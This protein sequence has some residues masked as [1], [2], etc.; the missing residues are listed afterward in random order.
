MIKEI[1]LLN[2]RSHQDST[3]TFS[4]GTNLL[5][6]MMGSGK[7]SILDGI[8]FALF[9]T[10][11]A[12]ERR[13]LKL[14]DIIRLNEKEAKVTLSLEWG[15]LTYKIERV[16]IRTKKST[17]S[18]ASLFKNNQ[19]L[20]SGTR[21]VSSY[22]EELLGIDYDLFTRAIYAEQ[23]NI[24]YFL[25]LDPRRRKQEIDRLLGLDRFEE[26]RTNIVS[27]I[28]RI[29]SNRK[30]LEQRF[31][32]QRLE[33]LTKKQS[34]LQ[35]TID[36]LSSKLGEYSTSFEKEQELLQS[37]QKRFQDLKQKK[38][39][40]D[41]L[42][43][44]HT[45]LS[46]SLDSLKKEL[47][48]KQA[49]P[50]QLNKSKLDLESKSKERRSILEQTRKFDS[51]FSDL[52]KQ[53]GLLESEV[54]SI[55]EDMKKSLELKEN[56]AKLLNGHSVDQLNDRSE[57]LEK[58]WISVNSEG[59]SLQTQV[60]EIQEAVNTL[61]PGTAECPIC[62]N[63][64][65][66]EHL[67]NLKQ[68]KEKLISEKKQRI[69]FLLDS[70]PRLRTERQEILSKI[71][72]IDSL[73][74][75]I[76]LLSKDQESIQKLKE[77]K[78]LLDQKL[79]LMEKSKHETHEKSE[80]LSKTIEN[81]NIVVRDL[82]IIIKNKVELV[83]IEG[84]LATIQSSIK[85]LC[86]DESIFE[87][88]RKDLEET[89]LRSERISSQIQTVNKDITS[90]KDMFEVLKKELQSLTQIK[91]DV[92]SSMK[93][94]EELS[95]FKNALLETQ[96]SLRVN[97]TDAIN[98]AMNEVW[99]IF[100]PYPNY[101]SIRLSVGEKDYVFQVYDKSEWKNIE[102]IAS[103][104]ERASAA[105]TLR[106]ALAMVLTPTL[107]WLMLDEPT[108]NLDR[109]AIELLSG[110]LQLKVPE[111]VKQ[112]FVITHEES[113]AGSDFASNYKLKRNKS[114]NGPTEIERI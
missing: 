19:M 67:D 33:E 9:G 89:R 98:S 16:I 41:N 74:Q 84:K 49:D 39:R 60:K 83:S 6:G 78:K 77:K 15:G 100:Y 92:S 113:L 10:F 25:N 109:E 112:T 110:T 57:T 76:E 111:V 5:I 52:S 48:D 17:S 46:G 31:S 1:R 81:L 29:R 65:T 90:S 56:L 95:I 32:E 2:W 22:I 24:D 66:Q 104:G 18:S 23:N 21:S 61:K 51:E 20:E 44:E 82:E 62:S 102:S 50:E 40:F 13:K 8:S 94:E 36:T 79:S 45:R 47:S 27:V 88:L 106:V 108:H 68:E 12:L 26:A 73:N 38:E 34:D 114:Q 53:A 101:P 59:K 103:G 30:V 54:K 97:L 37:L 43:K 96:T 7:S 55:E 28:N 70:L 75:K 72:Q 42:T 85:E 14:D 69:R 71:K 99:S 93:L 107:S 86:F 4:K 105:L 58:E 87:T 91:D 11:P 3:L 80:L 35:T 63:E 64:L